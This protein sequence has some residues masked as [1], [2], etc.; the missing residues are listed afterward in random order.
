[1]HGDTQLVQAAQASRADAAPAHAKPLGHHVVVRARHERDDPEQFL[2]ALGEGRV[3]GKEDLQ[4]GAQPAAGFGEVR[5]Q[6]Y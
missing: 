2:A 4:G 6:V 5:C 3:L 1:M